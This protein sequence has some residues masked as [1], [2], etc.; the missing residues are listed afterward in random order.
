MQSL[1]SAIM[2]HSRKAEIPDRAKRLALEIRI[3][4]FRNILHGNHIAVQIE[5][6]LIAV[7]KA[8]SVLNSILLDISIKV[9]HNIQCCFKFNT[10]PRNRQVLA[11]YGN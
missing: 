1:R 2:D 7:E 6:L 5:G 10:E 9:P 11:D 8:L 4:K 3:K